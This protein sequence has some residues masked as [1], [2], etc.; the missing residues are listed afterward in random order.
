MYKRQCP[1]CHSP[2]KYKK[3]CPVCNREVKEPLRGF[4]LGTNYVILD[5]SDF[6]RVKIRSR[7]SIEIEK[8]APREKIPQ[9]MRSHNFYLVPDT[10]GEKIYALLVK[11]LTNLDHVGIGKFV[12]HNREHIVELAPYKNAL[13][14]TTLFYDNE[15]R[16]LEALPELMSKVELSKEELKLGEEIIRKMSVNEID[17]SEYKDKYTE[18]LKKIIEAKS[19]GQLITIEEQVDLHEQEDLMD[20]LR[21]SLEALTSAHS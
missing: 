8:F 15:V 3:W 13:L 18:G 2:I 5:E 1:H 9:V 17:F 20:S 12:L 16:K 19:K 10:G 6:E 7:H 4:K 14:L 21:A 11:V